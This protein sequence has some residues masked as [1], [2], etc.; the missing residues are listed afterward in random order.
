M[1]FKLIFSEEKKYQKSKK[2]AKQTNL[3]FYSL[4]SFVISAPKVFH[5]GASE[6]VVIQALGY[7][8]AFDVTISIR[9]YP[10]RKV[11]LFRPC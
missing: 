2:P 1:F 5:V 7:T 6:S 8:E 3:F 9:S 10:D 11:I 4:N